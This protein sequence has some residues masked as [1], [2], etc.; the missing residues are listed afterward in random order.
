MTPQQIIG[1][2]KLGLAVL[3]AV[4][5]G[6]DLG[7]PGGT[8]YAAMMHQGANLSQFQSFMGTLTGRGMLTQMGDCYYITEAGKGFKDLLQ[9]KFGQPQPA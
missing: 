4:S 5:D 1:L 8:L 7:A 6:G 9:A 2:Q 3:E